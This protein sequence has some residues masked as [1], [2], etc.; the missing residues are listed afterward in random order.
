MQSKTIDLCYSFEAK[1]HRAMTSLRERLWQEVDIKS[2]KK[3]LAQC[4]VK[5]LSS[6]QKR[7]I[8]AY[9]KNLTGKDVPVFWHEYFYSRNGVFS[10]RYVP[11]S[12]YH[13]SIIYHLNTRPLTM[14]YTD[15]C[16]Y[17]N[18]LS[19][20]WRPKT[21]V[22]NING[23]FYDDSKP[24]TNEEAL[25]IC[26]N[27]K[28]V[29]IKPSMIGMWGTGVLIF[30]SE[31]GRLS[32]NE[33]VQDLFNKFDKNFIIQKKVIQHPDMS[34]LNPTSLNTLRVLSFRHED[35]VTILYAVVRIG[36]KD[37]MVDN[38][39][40]GGINAD[41][42]LT[43]GYI[44]DCAYGTPAEKRI[45]TTDIGTELKGF[46]IP[47]FDKVVSVVKELHKRLPYFHMVGWDFGVDDD[48]R[49]VM[50]EWNRCPD[51]S[52]TAHGP[53]FGDMTE[54][55]VKFAMSLPDTFDSRMWN[56]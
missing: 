43:N 30:S 27:L 5:P 41:V 44:K 13:S 2:I 3:K 45:L 56:G 21:I 39:T 36:R 50:I 10:E 52:Q 24:I 38:E 19:D 23:F 12:L 9:W 42:D 48:G 40:A 35:E 46:K 22:R 55:I 33:T 17:D 37:K 31:N 20:V 11:T 6:A 16:S 25:E 7:E 4:D 54:E 15:K 18:Y 47:S 53:A 32:E 29:V 51:L 28:D 8:Q 49:P 1:M 26:K 34:R 14:A